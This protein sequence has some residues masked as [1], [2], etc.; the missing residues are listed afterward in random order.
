SVACA[1]DVNN[2]GY[3]DL[4]VGAHYNDENGEQA[5]K[6]Y[7]YFGGADMDTV[8]DVV[9]NG[10][11]GH[12][13]FGESVAGVGDVNHDGY[14][15]VLIGSPYDFSYGSNPGKAY[16]FYGGEFMDNTPDVTFTGEQN[17]DYFGVRVSSAGD[18]NSDGYIDLVISASSDDQ[19]GDDAGKVYIYFGAAS[20]DNQPDLKFY[21]ES[22]YY[23]LGA[24]LAAIGDV[25]LNGIPDLLIGSKIYDGTPGKAYLYYPSGPSV[26]PHIYSISDVPGDQGGYLYLQ[27]SRS[28]Y[29]KPEI[30]GVNE[31]LIQ[32]S[33]KP[34]YGPYA[35]ESVATITASHQPFYSYTVPTL[36]D[37]CGETN[38]RAYYRVVARSADGKDS[39]ISNVVSAYSLDNLAPQSTQSLNAQVT[40]DSKV[41]LNWQKNTVDPDVRE[42]AVYRSTQEGFTPSEELRI[43]TTTDTTYL[44]ENPVAGKINYYK[45]VTIDIHDNHSDPSP[46]AAADLSGSQ[47]QQANIPQTFKLAQNFPNPFNPGTL[48]RYQLPQACRVTLQ[49]YDLLGRKIATLVD[50]KQEA[51]Y[52]TIEFKANELPSGLYIYRL[53][54]GNFRALRKMIKLK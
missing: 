2:D 38:G 32:R 1:G 23:Q 12:Y 18:I 51:G 21:G 5:G 39:W 24:G 8:A 53:Q 19:A 27:F 41:N 16:L 48:I 44:D 13:H 46:E 7:I 33:L 10:E 45:V 52:Y 17:N 54:A 34:N 4:I 43:A 15:D 37:S 22:P 31:Y 35:W 26:L 28:A 11:G 30:E 25:N 40:E 42:Y 50:K 20:M 3:S 49:V 47:V 36:N 14:D 29:D 9:M 6:V